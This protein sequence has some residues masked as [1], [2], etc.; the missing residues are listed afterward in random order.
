MSA[1]PAS[2]ARTRG[3][4]VVVGGGPAGLA[5]AIQARLS[6]LPVTVLDRARPPIDKPCGE[7]LMPDGVA[8]L[9]ALGVELPPAA[10]P[11]RGI[12]YLDEQ[13]VAEGR[14]PAAGSTG[15]G[16][17]ARGAVGLGIRR[18]ELHAAMV[19]RAEALGVDLAWGERVERVLG[20]GETADPAAPKGTAV[21][22]LTAEGREVLGDWL[23]GADG[24][25][26]RVRR[27]VAGAGGTVDPRLDL[28]SDRPS[29]P[30]GPGR[31]FGV[32]RHLRIAPWTDLVEVH[33]SDRQEGAEAYVTPVGPETVGVAVLW[34]PEAR[35]GGQAP[36]H[37][38]QPEQPGRPE[39]AARPAVF[40]DLLA[41]FPRLADRVAG[42]P[43]VSRD[44]GCGPLA[45]RVPAVA[46]GRIA[47]VGDAGGYLDAITGEGLSLA[48]HQ[49]EALVGTIVACERS[50][51][52]DLRR[53][54]RAH[55]RIPAGAG[56]AHPPAARGRAPAGPAPPGAPRARRRAGA[57]RPHPRRPRAD[58]AA[59]GPGHRRWR[60]RVRG[61]G[62][63]P[64]V[65][66]PPGAAASAGRAPSIPADRAMSV[67]ARSLLDRVLALA[68]GRP[69]TVLALWALTALVALPGALRLGTDNSPS[70]YFVEGSPAL[71]SYRELQGAFGDREQVRLLA[72]G[73]GLWT[74]D[75]LAR[76]GALE[77]RVLG[78]SDGEG[79]PFAVGALGLAGH[80][81]ALGG[82]W[83][84]ADPARFAARAARDPVDRQLGLVGVSPSGPAGEAGRPDAA[85]ILVSIA[86]PDDRGRERAVA[87][88]ERLAAEASGGGVSV[89]AVG[90]PV[91]DR[92]LDASSR[93]I[94]RVYFPL[95][96]GL[97]VLLL[98][99]T[100]RTARGVVLP[101]AFVAAPEIVLLGAMGFLGIDLNLVLAILPPLLFVISLATAVHLTIR[102][103][104]A[105]DDGAER[106]TAILET[107]D[108][109]GW[110]VFWT[111][112][113]T[114]IGFGSLAVSRVGP[115]PTLGIAS[116]AGI[117]LMT[118]A[119]FTLY[120]ALLA[121]FGGR[122][123]GLS[124]TGAGRR[125][126]RAFERRFRRLGRVWA[127][128]AAGH[129]GV[130]L[131]AAGA[132][133]LAALA[134]LP[135]L[136][137]E[138]DAVR[139]LPPDHPARRG[140][141]R[142]E[143][144]GIGGAAIDVL[145]TLPEDP[146]ATGRSGFER[147]DRLRGLEDLSSRL[148]ELPRVL[149]AFGG[150][151]AVAS[152]AA[153][154]ASV[155]PV[156]GGRAAGAADDLAL[157]ALLGQPAGRE[158]FRSL[159]SEDGR[160]A[161]VIVF[162]ETGGS[163]ELAP[164]LD[165]AGAAARELVSSWDGGGDET[166]GKARG[167]TRVAVTGQ[168][169]LMLE[170]HRRLL[171]T[172]ALSLTLTTVSIGLLFR[173]LLPSTRLALLALVPNLWPVAVTVG[174]MGWAGIPL[175][176]ATV[177]VAS[178]VLGLAVDDTIHT[179]GHFRE[180]AP[181]LGRREAVAGTL[182]RTAPAYVL[183]GVILAVGFGVCG[184]SEFAP[185]ARFGG[186][187]ALAIIL[188]VLGDLVLLPALLGATPRAVVRRLG[189]ARS[190]DGPGPAKGPGSG[191]AGGA[192][193]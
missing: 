94:G 138:S 104:D 139:F 156:P 171:V 147:P 12:R 3:R 160:R 88:L 154:T 90:L 178:V 143:E 13:T 117:A 60:S 103:R 20:A 128:R 164:T 40:D 8:R 137:V 141:E 115:V 4:I 96:A 75:G 76:L 112:A 15:W 92:A 64:P 174:V 56:R 58:A 27:H 41:R 52:A 17:G 14:F 152:V 74:R 55:R 46:R 188:A 66:R 48:F 32:R 165:G 28:R 2:R 127:D 9:E 125:D 1:R 186:L 173:W 21:G 5:V 177:M 72:T 65:R 151:D 36:D 185:T 77:D 130:V 131:V 144:H 91:I 181:V 99:L 23:V 149:G 69:R 106:R 10:R 157:R 97:A 61:C 67:A 51:A 140:I 124:K 190:D 158:L 176:T 183:T 119:A 179:L 45:Q 7:G 180:L 78:G 98:A 24:L 53:Y 109:K 89:E 142:L 121:L 11:F 102:F 16:G 43:A 134:G 25:L 79:V 187:S 47:L 122:I 100:L 26:S 73:D 37:S 113:T 42:A 114:M 38:D 166:P 169:P 132:V 54:V 63:S 150:G 155:P 111:G 159:V 108:D 153:L 191:P 85:T 148:R 86:P 93:E 62:R 95:L 107:Y 192:S 167:E 123:G 59:P 126:A 175:D 146:G 182:A 193:D 87:A 82:A 172:L 18:T 81:R 116:A 105:V 6:D 30:G 57:V 170:T 34:S 84:P 145:L 189:G 135:R 50:G 68:V 44:L 136:T 129:R 22:V 33:W 83:P 35:S 168:L 162:V 184:L 163:R 118:L 29:A 110:A 101:L 71:A 80:R 31:R 120:P 161:R 70:V 19:R 39:K 133:A 49:A